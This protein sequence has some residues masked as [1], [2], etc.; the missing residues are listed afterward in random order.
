MARE[1]GL[2]P[3]MKVFLVS[4]VR[5][6][7]APLRLARARKTYPVS[8]PGSAQKRAYQNTEAKRDSHCVIG[9]FADGVVGCFGSS[10][11]LVFEPIANRFGSL[12]GTFQIGL[13]FLRW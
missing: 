12:D 10:D 11:S 13:A 1:A 9:I 4:S 8:V 6:F 7:A 5:T 2:M 3:L